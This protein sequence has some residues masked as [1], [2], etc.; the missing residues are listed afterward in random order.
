MPS[1]AHRKIEAVVQLTKKRFSNYLAFCAQSPSDHPVPDSCDRSYLLPS[2]SWKSWFIMIFILELRSRC[3]STQPN[4]HCS[5][6][7]PVS[8]ISFFF[9]TV[10]ENFLRRAGA[11][12]FFIT[13]TTIQPFHS[14]V[15]DIVPDPLILLPALI[16]HSIKRRHH[17]IIQPV[18][19][20]AMI[21]HGHITFLSQRWGRDKNVSRDI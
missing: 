15:E 7:S 20:R 17:E 11:I 3:N 5:T 6:Y 19:H 13:L 4:I 9:Q 21:F 12:Y 2:S 10:H 16:L 8:H 18:H 1:R 14:I